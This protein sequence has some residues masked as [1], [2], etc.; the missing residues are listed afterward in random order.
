MDTLKFLLFDVHK[1]QELLAYERFTDFDTDS[2]TIL[3]ESAKS[4]ADQDFYPYYK[5]MDE[6]PVYF[7]DGIT[8]SHPILKKY[9][10]TQVK[11]GALVVTLIIRMEVCKCH[12]C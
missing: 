7:K 6:K 5:E 4:W 11:T 8:Y 9:L 2:F 1:I 10:S 3:L 12:I